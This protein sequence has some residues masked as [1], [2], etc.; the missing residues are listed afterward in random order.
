MGGNRKSRK[1]NSKRGDSSEG[2]GWEIVYCGFVLILL[3]FFIMLCSFAS[4]EQGKVVRFVKSFVDALSIFSGGIK[5][6][7]G[8][9]VMMETPDIVD[10]ESELAYL[11]ENV[12]LIA[13]QLGLEKDVDVS[14]SDK[15]FLIRVAN[16]LLYDI[17]SA[18][19][20][21]K[22]FMFLNK[23]AF[24]IA[25]TSYP[26]RIEGHTDNLPIH[27]ERYSSNWDLSTARA[28][29]ILRY[30]TEKEGI[31]VNRIS[32]VGLGEFH[33]IFPNDTPEHRSKNRRV[34]IVF[35]TK[36]I[37]ESRQEK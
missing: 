11:F 1:S 37:D 31:P 29:N 12:M 34:E 26:I 22:S 19:I 28:V 18:E 2:A 15:G 4:I 27:N 20:S 36:G 21:T 32:A 7:S 9:R 8:S 24:V 23:L 35:D 16:T 6:E 10:K 30:F 13:V 3:C 14:S 33:P 25:K 5:L 17:G